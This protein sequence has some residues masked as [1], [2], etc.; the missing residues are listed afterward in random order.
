VGAW[1][2][3]YYSEADAG[4]A[5]CFVFWVEGGEEPLWGAYVVAVTITR[6]MLWMLWRE[7]LGEKSIGTRW[8][9][10][11]HLRLTLKAIT[12]SQLELASLIEG[13]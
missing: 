13:L 3:C 9:S 10:C 5:S 11:R 7:R 2:V 6:F 12:Q 8:P 1:S 4:L